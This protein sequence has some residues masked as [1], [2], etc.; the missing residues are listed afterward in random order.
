MEVFDDI[1]ETNPEGITAEDS[2]VIDDLFKLT[3]AEN[4][5]WRDEFISVTLKE[6]YDFK[7]LRQ[8][9]NGNDK[10]LLSGLEVPAL[11]V[12][13]INRNL[14][15]INGIRTNTG[16]KR[17]I[18][19]RESGDDRI[20][21]ILDK[22]CDYVD[23]QGNF[24]EPEDES[25][26]SMTDIGMGIEKIGCD[27]QNGVKEIWLENVNFEDFGYSKGKRKDLS[28]ISWCWQKQVMDWEKAIS[29]NPAKA[30]EI[31]GLK[32]VLVSEWDKLNTPSGSS[33]TDYRGS[34]SPKP[35]S[36]PDQVTVWEFWLERHIPYKNVGTMVDNGEMVLP[37][38]DKMPIDYQVKEG[39]TEIGIEM[40]KS[41]WQFIVCSGQDKKNA[42]LL[43][44][45]KYK[46]NHHPYIGKCAERK[47]GGAPRGYIEPA[48]M[49]QKRINLAWAQKVAY[50][51]KSIK[52]PLILK[53][54]KDV[55]SHLKQSQLGSVLLLDSME[56]F[57][58]ANVQPP[59]NLQAIEEGNMARQDM[60]FAASA[61]SPAMTGESSSGDSGLK[62]SLEQKAALTPLNKW[63]KAER[64]A[65][66][67]L[68]RKLLTIIITEFPPERMARIVGEQR[69]MQLV[70]PQQ[71]M[72]GNII[73]PPLQMPLQLDV[74]NYDVIMTDEALADFNKQQSFNASIGLVQVG[75]VFD[76]EFM[77]KNAPIKNTDEALASNQKKKQDIMQQM[78]QQMQMMQEQI[79]E[80]Q[81]QVPKENKPKGN[82]NNQGSKGKNQSQA[83]KRE[84]LGGQNFLG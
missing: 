27:S 62:V 28:D 58:Q 57:I 52:S 24:E 65:R 14:D 13:R 83:G 78:M 48:I 59:I 40:D 56:E 32:T 46:Y 55:D 18:V 63:I 84:M 77:I 41:W 68:W 17:K 38:I 23:Y 2:K 16:G 7:E 6:C 73:A 44:A 37:K 21:E 26:N 3:E 22:V 61:G 30:G 54:V 31:K 1:K 19:K 53:G 4:N 45:G 10:I 80:L 60:D 71:D 39:E 69:F 34:T 5:P 15:T 25:F 66:L 29:I 12:D 36:Y 35:T 76:D 20:A 33:G 49:P 47:K 79:G 43:G 82:P 50:N 42:I 75:V 11:A 67:T 74:A 9:E 81:K 72:M 70:S 8:W 64:M 51:N